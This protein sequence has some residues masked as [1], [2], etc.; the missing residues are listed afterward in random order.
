MHHKDLMRKHEFEK[1]Q[2][3]PCLVRTLAHLAKM[4]IKK[5]TRQHKLKA[6]RHGPLIRRI[7]LNSAQMLV[8]PSILSLQNLNATNVNRIVVNVGGTKYEI[9]KKNL[10]KFPDTLLGSERKKYFFDKKRMEYFFDRDPVIFKNIAEFYRVGSFHVSSTS[11]ACMEAVLDELTFFGIPQHMVSDCCC[12]HIIMGDEELEKKRKEMEAI[13]SKQAREYMLWTPREKLWEFLTNTKSSKVS[14][15]FSYLFGAVVALNISTIIAETVPTATESV[16]HVDTLPNVFFGIDSFCVGI[17]TMEYIAR[18]YSAPNRFQFVRKMSNVIDLLGILPYYIGVLKRTVKSNSPVLDFILPVLRMFRVFRVT[19]LARHSERFQNLLLSV[20]SAATELGGILFSF[21]ALM[22]TFSSMMYYF[23]KDEEKTKFISIPEAFWYTLVT[24]TTLGYGDIYPTTVR[25]KLLGAGCALMGVLLLSL[26]VPIIERKLDEFGK[27][28][29]PRELNATTKWAVS[30]P[31]I[32]HK[33]GAKQPTRA[34]GKRKGKTYV[35][36]E[37]TSMVVQ[38]SNSSNSSSESNSSF[39]SSFGSVIELRNKVTEP[40]IEEPGVLDIHGN[41]KTPSEATRT[42]LQNWKTAGAMS[43]GVSKFTFTQS[44]PYKKY[45]TAFPHVSAS[46]GDDVDEKSL[47]D[48]VSDYNGE[49]EMIPTRKLQRQWSL[50]GDCL[51]VETSRNCR[52]LGDLT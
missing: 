42:K 31:S 25:G 49:K 24:M 45:F 1:L 36:A 34:N 28:S 43:G 37:T 47:S 16:R 7:L 11:T 30:L 9:A 26:P 46:S 21:L 29:K 51:T 2:Q 33:S 6:T 3:G 44:L 4:K 15:I 27:K 48:W 13:E 22:V 10:E 12:E 41:R 17:F 18:L 52:S 50:K 39:H 5:K 35:D 32:A 38:L 14:A 20:Q 19:K 40:L 8:S 23:E